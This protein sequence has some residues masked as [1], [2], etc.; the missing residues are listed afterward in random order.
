[1]KLKKQ[2]IK[3]TILS[4]MVLITIILLIIFNPI[5]NL[6]GQILLYTLLPIW[7][8]SIIPGYFYVA[9]L[10]NKM[11]FEETLKIGFVL[12][13]VLGFFVFFLPFFLAPYLMVKYYLY[14][15]VKIKQEEQ[16]EGFN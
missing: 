10:L 13:V 4:T 12:G 11:T 5:N 3:V 15:C 9:F 7:G 2:A 8:F 6:I 1:M 16:L 14:I